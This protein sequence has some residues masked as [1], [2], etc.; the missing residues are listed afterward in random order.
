MRCP[1]AIASL[2]TLLAGCASNPIGAWQTS[3]Q[4][5]VDENGNGDVNVLRALDDNPDESPAFSFYGNIGPLGSATNNIT[6]GAIESSLGNLSMTEY[7]GWG[8]TVDGRIK[9]DLVAKGH[10]LFSPFSDAGYGVMFGTSMA[11]AVVSGSAVLV[12]AHYEDTS[13]TP[14]TNAEVKA[15]LINSPSNPTGRTLQPTE[16]QAAAAFARRHDL[17][18]IS[19]EIYDIFSFDGP[20]PSM[21][22]YYDQTL[23]LGGFSKTYGMPGWRLNYALPDERPPI[24]LPPALKRR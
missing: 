15:L 12:A 2:L 23:L 20:A 11:A 6:V 7:S 3:V 9:P 18:I 19:D 4:R 14:P 17:P 5:Y 13:A 1:A 16:L 8:P 22:T 24:D 21:L 10:G